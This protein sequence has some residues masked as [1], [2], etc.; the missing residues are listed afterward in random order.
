MPS[1]AIPDH[2]LRRLA[3]AAALTTLLF[4]AYLVTFSGQPVSDDERYIIDTVD[5]LATRGSLLLNQT[6][7]LRPVQTTDVEPGQPLISVPLYWLAYRIPWAGNVHALFLL[8]PLVTALTGALLFYTALD[9]G[10]RERTAVVATLLFGLTTIVWPYTK[11]YF[12]EPLTMLNLFAAAFLLNR[13]RTAFRAG[14]R[15]HWAYLGAGVLVTLVALL[16]K[17]A[18]LIALPVLLLIAYPGGV[19][20]GRRS[21]QIV[22]IAAWL[23]VVAAI[24]GVAMFVFRTDLLAW[25]YRYNVTRRLS[26]MLTNLPDIWRG[27]GGYLVSPGKAVW[28]TSPVL[29]L[30]LGAPFA[31]PRKRW[32]ESWLPLGLLMI[33]V[34]TYAAVRG[35]QWSGGTGWGAR[36]MA[37]I[38]PFLMIAALPLLDRMLRGTARWPKL[39]LAGLALWGFA[40]QV[41]GSYVYL[42]SYYDYLSRTITDTPWQGPAVW[43]FRWSQPLGSLLY[44][45]QAETDIRWLIPRVDWPTLAVLVAALLLAGALAGWLHLRGA[46]RRRVVVAAL[47]GA[48]LLALLVAMFALR[49]AYDDPRYHG[50]IPA[51]HEMRA[52]LAEHAAPGDTIMLSSPT[53]VPHFMNYYKGAATW[54]SLPWAPGERYS[55][56]Q[57][58]A[59]AEGSTGELAGQRAVD[60]QV[61]FSQGGTFYNGQPIWLVMDLGP[62]L[63][64]APRPVEQYFSEHNYVT[65]TV[66]FSQYA[67]L[68]QVLPYQAPPPT[69]PPATAVDARFGEAIRLT[70]F[71]VV[72]N[73]EARAL[74]TVR[75]GDRLGL[76]LLWEAAAPVEESYTVALH[77]IGPDGLPLMQHDRAP[78]G[79]FAPTNTWQPGAALRDNYGFILPGDLPPGGYQVW[80]VIYSWPSLERLPVTGP[81][82]EKL[83]DHLV[84]GGFEVR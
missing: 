13:W 43:S 78:V 77:L 1:L 22:Q 48:P 49:Q 47:A 7:Y 12:R 46:V 62:D 69:H 40:V 74:G 66:D 65:S 2:G 82:G 16:S 6:S 4:L 3:L 76:S 26:A 70:G 75:P 42:F 24:A 14:V 29:L 84:L 27:I 20:D 17:E 60:A 21:R 59:V 81:D 38:T 50:N 11:T 41:G 37:P 25:T 57:A 33:F 83:G 45:P 32:R 72:V 8:S 30:A 19:I 18:A 52:Y 39:A 61:I 68:V 51:V 15:H 64:W 54:Y 44:L 71:D 73:G 34:V 9:L 63:P 10:Y 35:V 5:S 80:A 58:P 56:E 79:G 28:W 23:V 36:Y 53:Y 55:P 31:L 67:R